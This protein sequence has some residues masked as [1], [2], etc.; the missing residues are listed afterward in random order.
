ML[1]YI[2]LTLSGQGEPKQP[3]GMG[4]LAEMATCQMEFKYLSHVTK[5]PKYFRSSQTVMDVM[6]REQGKTPARM[7]RVDEN[8]TVVS[9]E[10]SKGLK[11]GLW[12]NN[13]YL[14][15]GGMF[16]GECAG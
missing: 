14:I 16:G 7:K 9:E 8:G 15:D 2:G 6:Q 1:I 4:S 13:F 10:L 11:T 3:Q 12:T 5:E